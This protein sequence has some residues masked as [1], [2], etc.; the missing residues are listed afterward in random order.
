MDE[1]QELY[2]P[3]ILRAILKTGLEGY[4]VQGFIIPK[5]KDKVAAL[6]QGVTICDV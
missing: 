4:V 5:G 3:A 6:K 2:Y 1:T